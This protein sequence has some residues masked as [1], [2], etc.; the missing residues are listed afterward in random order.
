M[1]LSKALPLMTN[2]VG[3]KRVRKLKCTFVTRGLS[4]CR[5]QVP[6][7]GDGQRSIRVR[8][9]YSLRIKEGG[10][11][12]DFLAKTGGGQVAGAGGTVLHF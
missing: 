7:L 12:E 5:G 4:I 3:N 9:C 8:A 2:N 10:A 6:S 1:G 11:V